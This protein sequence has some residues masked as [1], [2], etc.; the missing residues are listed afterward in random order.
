M[1]IP[2]RNHG[3]KYIIHTRKWK[4]MR[5]TKRCNECKHNPARLFDILITDDGKIIIETKCVKDG[6]VS[7]DITEDII[8]MLKS[9][10]QLRPLAS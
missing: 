1:F 9:N 8:N 6:I 7:T 3:D 10:G 4:M 5:T 2:C